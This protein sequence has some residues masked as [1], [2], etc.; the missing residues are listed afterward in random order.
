VGIGTTS[1]SSLLHISNSSTAPAPSQV[2]I[3]TTGDGGAGIQF[4]NTDFPSN[5][6]Q[7]FLADDSTGLKIG[8]DNV[9]DYVTFLDGGDVEIITGSLGVG[10]TP[11]A[12]NGRIDASNDIVAFST[13][14]IRW[15]ENVEVIEN[16]LEKIQEIS[17]VKFTWIED[18]NFHG[19]KG[20]DY[21]VI[22]Q[23]V[24]KILPEAVQTRKT[25]MK[26][27]RYEKLIPLLIEVVK[28]QQKQ[29]DELKNKLGL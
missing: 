6:F 3:E 25:G 1:P 7:L 21:G 5:T 8:R 4:K 19:N 13:S 9:A 23:E 14:D 2:L 11:N 29:I 24:E 12:T 17:G 26:A 16:P 10:V 28:E 27:V 22:A 20:Q 18:T 15:K